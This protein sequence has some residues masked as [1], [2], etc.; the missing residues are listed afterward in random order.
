MPGIGLRQ[1]AE[2]TETLVF[3]PLLL[4]YATAIIQHIWHIGGY[5]HAFFPLTPAAS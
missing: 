2:L 5:K 3:L 4:R 1:A